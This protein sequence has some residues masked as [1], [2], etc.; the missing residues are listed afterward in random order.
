MAS[1]SASIKGFNSTTSNVI[2]VKPSGILLGNNA[3]LAYMNLNNLYVGTSVGLIWEY[4]ADGS[5]WNLVGTGVL[6]GS[7][8]RSITTDYNNNIYVGTDSGNVYEYNG[9]IW[10]ILGFTPVDGSFINTVAFDS[11]RRLYAVTGAGNVWQYSFANSLWNIE[12]YGNEI[13]LGI[14]KTPTAAGF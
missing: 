6:D 1:F 9:V 3:G 10:F 5:S 2:T 12:H 14:N 13:F 8:I 4:S 11:A 7:M